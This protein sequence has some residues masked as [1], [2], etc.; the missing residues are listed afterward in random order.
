M[1]S[2]DGP[3][4]EIGASIWQSRA[5]FPLR[6]LLQGGVLTP[7]SRQRPGARAG[8]DA[9]DH[10]RVLERNATVVP[11]AGDVGEMDVMT[12][13]AAAAVQTGGHAAPVPRH[14]QD[15]PPG[16]LISD[17]TRHLA[18][19]LCLNELPASVAMQ[20][21][22]LLLGNG[23]NPP[24]VCFQPTFRGARSGRRPVFSSLSR[25]GQTHTG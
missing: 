22:A 4:F 5:H 7:L 16:G 13:R 10:V 6:L 11:A 17:V 15:F 9:S 18:Q 23:R 24:L 12:S 25:V 19:T 1:I 2:F 20:R 21:T 8:D 14:P 3:R